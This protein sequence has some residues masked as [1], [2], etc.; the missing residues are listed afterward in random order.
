M[1]EGV[2]ASIVL[3]Q[4][5]WERLLENISAI[6]NQVEKVVLVINGPGCEDVIFEYGEKEHFFI[7]K[8]EK[9]EGIAFALNQAMAYAFEQK[10]KWVLTLDQDTVVPEGLVDSLLRH[11]YCD[12]IGIIAPDFIDRNYYRTAA[13]KKGWDFVLN[14]ITSASLTNVDAWKAVGGF[15]N[16]MFIDFV[17]YDYCANLIENGYAI[18]QNHDA[19]ILH[20]IGNGRRVYCGKYSMLVSN[21]SATRKYYMVRNAFYFSEKWPKICRTIVDKKSFFVFQLIGIVLFE[22]DK[23]KKIHAIFKGYVDSKKMIREIRR[24]RKIQLERN[25]KYIKEKDD[26][27]KNQRGIRNV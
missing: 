5:E 22:Q 1:N 4:P 8:N 13:E 7:I 23:V 14:C 10:Y 24:E 16:K 18:I 6:Q 11:Q 27:W 15:D 2:I 20:E 3:Y 9:N 25:R 17:D 26:E 19:K 21:H 12:R